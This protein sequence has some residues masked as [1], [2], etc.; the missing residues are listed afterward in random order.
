[1]AELV[2]DAY[3][4]ITADTD[5]MQR[6]LTRAMRQGGKAGADEYV[7]S[8]GGEV[9]RIADQRMRGARQSFAKALVDPK[10]FDRLAKSFDS[11]ESASAHW[12]KELLRLSRQQQVTT[13]EYKEFKGAIIAWDKAARAAR[14]SQIALTRAKEE[15]AEKTRIQTAQLKNFF[16]TQ[17]ATYARL[18]TAQK[19]TA[20]AAQKAAQVQAQVD[21]DHD[22]ALRMMAQVQAQVDKDHS[23]ALR[24]LANQQATID[25]DHHAALRYLEAQE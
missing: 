21:K 19:Q 15:D 18:Q 23:A 9:D 25:R 11:I 16:T 14:D 24:M 3:I 5:A 8:F 12:R 7:D 20:L 1:M 13:D 22:R 10:E 4:R 2:G 6:S 17:N